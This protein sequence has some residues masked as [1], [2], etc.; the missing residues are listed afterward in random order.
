MGW[1]YIAAPAELSIPFPLDEKIHCCTGPLDP[2]LQ[3]IFRRKAIKAHRGTARITD[4]LPA[5]NVLC[6]N[7][8]ISGGN[9]FWDDKCQQPHQKPPYRWL[10]VIRYLETSKQIPNAIKYG[11]FN[12][13]NNPGNNS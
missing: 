2:R 3:P 6:Q 7:P 9:S 1:S 13:S 11:R 4:R 12:R 8:T 10:D 5:L